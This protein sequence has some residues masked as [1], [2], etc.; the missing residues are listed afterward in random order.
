MSRERKK[1]WEKR[2]VFS[3]D[4]KTATESL[5]L[6]RTVFG[7]EFQIAGA[8]HRKARFANVG[9]AVVDY[10]RCRRF[11]RSNRLFLVA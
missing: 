2:T 5:G 9:I 10:L 8:E 3:L 1:V 7:S 4:L 11:W 6:L